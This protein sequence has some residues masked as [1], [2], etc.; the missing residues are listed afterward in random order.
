MSE[1][2]IQEM[3][4]IVRGEYQPSNEDRDR[5]YRAVIAVPGLPASPATGKGISSLTLLKGFGATV[6][7]LGLAAGVYL[8]VESRNSTDDTLPVA[9][10]RTNAGAAPAETT[11]AGPVV[12]APVISG[13]PE[14][15]P[16][17]NQSLPA[18]SE[19]SPSGPSDA[20]IHGAEDHAPMV[21]GA[22]HSGISGK[23]HVKKA[24]KQP[25]AP[26]DTL[27]DEMKLVSRAAA[28]INDGNPGTALTVLNQH[29]Q[30][31]PEGIMAQERNGLE[32]I[33]LCASGQ[34]AKGLKRYRKFK[35]RSPNAPILMRIT[36]TCGY[37]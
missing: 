7:T 18:V 16:L 6:L 25:E 29:R 32:I 3:L 24:E 1:R 27:A 13:T 23:A 9:A 31:F 5:I 11:A 20:E 37:Q 14:K 28:A 12:R 21:R 30:R 15:E 33:A 36:K 26:A 19:P 2:E 17:K 4:N 8:G 10:E 35:S 34:N 22:Q